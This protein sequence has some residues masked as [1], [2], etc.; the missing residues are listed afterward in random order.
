M[1]AKQLCALWIK[2]LCEIS[3]TDSLMM[4]EIRNSYSFKLL[5]VLEN[6]E[7]LSFPFDEK[8]STGPLK[9]IVSFL[10]ISNFNFKNQFYFES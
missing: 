6:Y 1:L 3:D 7:A 10:N 8:P 4:K 5:N 2:K 9:I